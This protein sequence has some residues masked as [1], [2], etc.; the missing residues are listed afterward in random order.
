MTKYFSLD[1]GELVWYYIPEY[2]FLSIN[3]PLG[4]ICLTYKE[5]GVIFIE[6]LGDAIKFRFFKT[7]YSLEFSH[8]I[9]DFNESRANALLE[10]LIQEAMSAGA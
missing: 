5:G 2:F 1:Q 9:E 6:H 10:I 7:D 4:Q 8:S 3:I